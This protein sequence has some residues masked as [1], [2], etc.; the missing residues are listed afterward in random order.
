MVEKLDDKKK[1]NALSKINYKQCSHLKRLYNNYYDPIINDKVCTMWNLLNNNLLKS[2]LIHDDCFFN[3]VSHSWIAYHNN[4]SINHQQS[5]PV[6]GCIFQIEFS[7]NGK[8]MAASNHYGTVD[9]WNTYNKKL[10]KNLNVHKEIVTGI[11]MFSSLQNDNFDNEIN[12]E[13]E[14]LLTSSLDKTIKLTK[15]LKVIHTFTEHNDWIKSLAISSDKRNFLSG[16]ISSVI[17][18]WDFETQ[19]VILNIKSD[20]IVNEN[21]L[22][23]VNS[24]KFYNNNDNTFVSAFR[25]GLVKIY[26]IRQRNSGFET[27]EFYKPAIKFK[28]HNVKLNAVKISKNDRHLLSSGR[29]NC[30]RL[31]DIRNL[32]SLTDKADE[33]KAINTYRGHKCEGFNIELSFM[34]KEKNVITGSEDGGIYVYEIDSNK[35]SMMYHTNERCVNIV[36]PFPFDRSNYSFVYAGLE[37]LHLFYCEPY[38]ISEVQENLIKSITNTPIG[39]IISNNLKSTHLDREKRGK[40]QEKNQKDDFSLQSIMED[41]MKDSGDSILKLIHTSNLSYSQDLDCDSILEK[42]KDLNDPVSMQ[43]LENLNKKF[44]E[45]LLESFAKKMKKPEKQNTK[46]K[47]AIET[48][49]VNINCCDCLSNQNLFEFENHSYEDQKH[50]LCYEEYI[51]ESEIFELPSINNVNFNL[52]FKLI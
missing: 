35:P 18:L 34:N 3:D 33:S 22:N 2:N 28:A 32:P 45:K 49:I 23:T 10:I 20:E 25:D 31:W 43:A 19:K 38:I 40:E 46:N 30:G 13:D 9:I 51:E 1:T 26:D 14:F 4:Q 42:L 52:N 36:K 8:Y 16:C 27:N 41:V 44:Q 12:F 39:V 29:D 47:T 24:L 21:N 11:E 17:K 15:N 6:E 50:P 5:G 48:K 37:H 7:E